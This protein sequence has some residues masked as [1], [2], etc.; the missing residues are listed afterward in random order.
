MPLLLALA[1][2]STPTAG[3]AQTRG[4][5]GS[6]TPPQ[7]HAIA[8][9]P[10]ENRV[11]L[12]TKELELDAGQQIAL[13]N[14]LIEHRTEV[15]KAWSDPSVPAA[16]RVGATQAVTEKT[17][18][19]IRAMLTDEQREKYIKPHRHET[20]GGTS[21]DDVQTWMDR[22]RRLEKPSGPRAAAKGS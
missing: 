10:L 20:A 2:G 4:E 18:A 14:V 13:R 15:A 3:A 22:S 19:R 8:S 21:G 1:A 11:Q 12:M 6:A 16:I 5:A 9:A 17:T 7:R